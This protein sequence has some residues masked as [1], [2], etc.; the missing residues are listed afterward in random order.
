MPYSLTPEHVLMSFWL[1]LT[2]LWLVL[3][4]SWFVSAQSYKVTR[5][6]GLFQP[7]PYQRATCW[8]WGHCRGFLSIPTFAWHL[9]AVTVAKDRHC[10]ISRWDAVLQRTSLLVEFP[11]WASEC[12]SILRFTWLYLSKRMLLTAVNSFF[13]HVYA[14]VSI[15]HMQEELAFICYV[16]GFFIW[17]PRVVSFPAVPLALTNSMSRNRPALGPAHT[18]SHVELSDE[19]AAGGNHL[20]QH[21]CFGV[22]RDIPGQL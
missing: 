7:R 15:H 3:L 17:S 11:A 16:L 18:S 5:R 21:L 20:S 1:D 10:A 12:L 4:T 14:P 19:K 2:W 9:I 8:N 22:F 13:E 6:R